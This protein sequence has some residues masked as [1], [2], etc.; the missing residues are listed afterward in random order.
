MGVKSSFYKFQLKVM[1]NFW[2]EN[3]NTFS[4]SPKKK[5]AQTFL[6]SNNSMT[7]LPPI[8][9]QFI[10]KSINNLLHV[11]KKQT[12]HQST[13]KSVNKSTMHV[14]KD[15]KVRELNDQLRKKHMEKI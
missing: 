8:D 4:Q 11:D 13:K 1:A 12:R 9:R 2:M 7:H 14:V 6:N 3:K 10:Q 15:K 5:K